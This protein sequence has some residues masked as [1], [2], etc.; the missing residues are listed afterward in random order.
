M[1]RRVHNFFRA[2][3]AC[4]ALTAIGAAYGAAPVPDAR[5]IYFEHLTMRDGLSQSTVM[6]ILQ[7]SEGYLWLATESGLDRY[8]GYSIRAYRRERGNEQGLASDFIWTI[9][10]DAR[11][12]LWLAT[13]GGG[14][15]RWDRR[16]DTFQQFRHDPAK[17]DSLASDAV[18]TLLIDASGSIWVGTEQ[19]LDVLDPKTGKAR[20]FRHADGDA[21]SLAGD[22]V[23]ALH[24]DHAGRLW[25]GTDAGLSR[26][27]AVTQDF[28]NYGTDSSG[29]ALSDVRIRVIRED[30]LGALW[31]G[32]LGGGLNRLDPDTGRIKTFRHDPQNAG[33]LSND[34][35]QA[36]LEDDAKRLWVA[37]RDGLN[38]FDRAS[39]KFVRYGRD[40]DNPQSLRAANVMSL[41]QDR[42]GVMWVGTRDGGASHWNP[43]SW[44]LGHYRSAA[45]GGGVGVNAFAEDGAGTVWVGTS[46]GLVEI[47]TRT[48]RETQYRRNDKGA[49][50]LADDNV[51]TL[52]LDR[53]SALWV[54]T[55]TA[56]LQRFDVAR[57]SVRNYQN[58]EGDDSTLPAN[59]VMALYEDRQG[60]LWVGTFGGGLA[61]I[62]SDTGAVV[63]YPVGDADALSDPRASAIAEDARGNLWI[64]TAGGGLNLLDRKTGRFHHYR[65]NDRDPNSLGD[66]AIYALHVDRHG[67]LWIGTAGGGLDRMIGSSEAPNAVRFESQSGFAGMTRQVVY[68]IESDIDGRLWLSTNN[69]LIRFDPRTRTTKSF[70]EAHG[71]QGEDFNFNAHY[72]GR[73]GTLFF[74]GSN[75]FN[76]FSP[77]AVTKDAPA[78]RVVLTSVAKLNQPLPLQDLPGPGKPLDLA[79]S[80]KLLT[81]EF[82]ALDFT[83]SDNNRYM[84]QLEG[85]DAGWTEA[86]AVRRATYTNL[87]AGEYTFRVRAANA[88]GAWNQDG[89]AIPVHVAA[90][91]WN[92]AL[93]RALYVALAILALGY[94]WRRQQLKRERAL[95]YSR[96]LEH[97][98]R[99]RTHELEERNQQLQVLSR[100]KSDFVARMS[101]ELRTPMNGVLGMTALL[102]DTRLDAAQRRFSEAIHRSADSLLAIVDD[103]LDFS[104]IEAGRLQLDPVDCDLV[105][106]VEQ[107]AEML[108][109]RAA[110][111]GIALLCDSPA[112][113]L[114]RVRVDAVRLRQVLVNLGGNAVKFTDR[115]HVTL[116]VTL[117]C[118]PQA[119]EGQGEGMLAIRLE[120]IDTGVG[121]ELANQAKIFEEFT[122]ED[123]STTRR[124]GG[125][126]LG[127]S[128]ARQLVELMG[129]K[130]GVVSAPGKG[131][132]FSF[133]LSLPLAEPAAQLSQLPSLD[134]MRAL[135]IDGN[136]VARSIIVKTLRE[137]GARPIGVATMA[138]AVEE[139]RATAYDAIIVDDSLASDGALL[140]SA[141]LAE[142]AT[143]PLSIRLINFV[144][145]ARPKVDGGLH[146]DAELSKPLRL[147]QLY[148][149]LSNCAGEAGDHGVATSLSAGHDAPRLRG[150]VLVV[151]DQ[152]LNR[153]VAEGMLA[154]LG[155]QATTAANGRQALDRL[156]AEEFDIV[157]MD[158][159]MPVM[160]GFSATAELRRREGSGSR[161]PIVALTANATSEGRE[162][163]L[164]AGMD[165][166][167]AKPFSRSALHAVL[168]R[169]LPVEAAAATS[170][171]VEAPPT[172]TPDVLDRA[173]LNALRALPRKGSKDMLSH[174]VERYLADSRELVSSI[175]RAVAEG[176]APELTRAAHAWRS[177]NGNVG[178]HGLAN[179]CRELEERARSG[180]IATT[181]ELLGELRALH[182]RVREELQFEMRRAG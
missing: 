78:P 1:R 129:G 114:P 123:A 16:T 7:D 150:R 163:C 117:P 108:A 66:D 36:V 155:L 5:P 50:A 174:I 118:L 75:G 154:A 87:D 135:V 12:D 98:V 113:P 24:A 37:T 125:T 111:K 153:E 180:K 134:P 157:L 69:G 152:A 140:L 71:L 19:G 126:G 59:G 177:Y 23:Y 74:G 60:D 148:R 169:W 56:G 45:F 33:S 131:S 93:A 89:I 142:R 72:R 137:W 32:T 10:E 47:D 15:A 166:Y 171:R 39:G 77:A 63:R 22:A 67:D 92:T 29:S 144:N 76:A 21:R 65:R 17:P 40:E 165:D 138:E 55:M 146:F 172:A 52:A 130:L 147:L 133:E 94:L 44:L 11:G 46:A 80:D 97:T 6:S 9:A 176:D 95:R 82:S 43:N 53:R 103:V 64:G 18:R 122:Q 167:L 107:T 73:D 57:H 170:A 181:P 104:K 139:L 105:E 91:P 100:A 30:H 85:F 68:G 116:R 106:L 13:V 28:V 168:A 179:L 121:I 42:G 162:A 96:E 83:S 49:L 2:F 48:G 109:A 62:V 128:I 173:T 102:L 25:V 61:R 156:A 79:Y 136:D 20:H 175:E 38:L 141:G 84:Y 158:C 160:D 115:G 182:T 90:A 132:V 81:F 70:H 58:V 51:M 124:F 99:V 41:Y 178:A 149:E 14:V 159:Q 145:L 151:E 164:A 120:V 88:D 3:L 27:D 35:V 4:S 54:G 34:R 119:G 26:Y 112:Q 127:L 8:D 101:H 143:R 110:T 161:L 31:I 86:G